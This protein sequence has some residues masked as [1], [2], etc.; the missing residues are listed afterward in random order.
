MLVLIGLDYHAVP[1]P[2]GCF[3]CSFPLHLPQ[4]AN[5]ALRYAGRPRRRAVPQFR[6]SALKT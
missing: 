6:W 4:H 3:S 5:E 1:A 2:V